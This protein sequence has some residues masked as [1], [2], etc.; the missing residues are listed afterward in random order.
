MRRRQFV[1]LVG[2]A[3]LAAAQPAGAQT[4]ADLPLVGLLTAGT[5]ADRTALLL[6]LQEAGF[7]E[8]AHYSLAARSGK[9]DFAR[10]PQLTT[11]L[12]ALKPRTIVAAG[13]AIGAVHRVLPDVPLVF[14][15]IVAD[16][17]KL[18][19]AE[20]YT[21]LGGMAAGNVMS[22]IGGEETITEKRIAR[23]KELAPGSET[24][25]HDQHDKGHIGHREAKCLA[26]SGSS[27]RL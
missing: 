2:S 1:G 4:R 18:G 24:A 13:S 23:F 21:R 11:E 25:W 10:L 26:K 17:V 22:A 7:V 6:G 5:P 9:G 19:L 20:S 16:P 8:G 14:T 27:S 12:G 3:A 15:G